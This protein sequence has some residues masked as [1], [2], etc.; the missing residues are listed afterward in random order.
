MSGRLPKSSPTTCAALPN[1]TGSQ[2]SA[3]GPSLFDSLDGE[4]SG[5]SGPEVV[6]VSPSRARGRVLGATIRATFGQRGF[7]SSASAALTQSLVSRLK[8]RLGTGGCALYTMT[9]KVKV[10]PSGRSVSRLAA[11]ALRTSDSGCG[12][13]A[14]PMAG[15]N[16]KSARAMSREG[17]SRNGGGQRSGPGLEQQAEMA[18]WP[19]PMAG[20]PSTEDYNA[21]G[22]TDFER[23]V[24]ALMG[25]RE[26]PNGPKLAGRQTPAVNDAKGSDYAYPSGNHETPFLKLPGQAKLTGW[27]TPAARDFKSES[28]TDQFNAERWAHQRGKPLSA[29]ATLAGWATPKANEKRRSEDFQEG[30]ALSAPEALGPK[31]TG[32]HVG[33]AGNGQLNPA[34]SRWLMGFPPEWDDCAPTVTRLSRRSRPSSSEQ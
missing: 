8:A 33:T 27:A 32:C 12:G 30:R 2:A 26:T 23:K 13:W 17:N 28:A 16:R 11:S 22:S 9:W 10:T 6:P 34:F 4:T 20:T 19:T 7:A 5:P 1:V 24:D 14:S 25:T 31:P 18:G 3:D 21:A 29:E 15:T